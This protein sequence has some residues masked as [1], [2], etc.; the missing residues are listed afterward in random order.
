MIQEEFETLLN[1]VTEKLSDEARKETPF[2]TSKDFENRVRE[3]LVEFGKDKNIDIDFAPHSYV[4]PDIAVGEF[5]IEVKFTAND[6]WRSVANSVFESTRNLEVTQV[7]IIFGKMGGIPAVRWGKYENC[8]MHVR[9]SHV[10][11]FEVEM[12]PEELL[13]E[14]IGITYKD[15]CDLPTEGK[16]HYIRQYARGRL[17]PGERLWW[18]EEKPE[19]EHSLP[20]QV[21]LFMHLS[22]EEKRKVRAEATLLCPQIVKSSRARNKYNDAALY[23]LTYHGVMCPQAR[24]LFSAGSVA[25]RANQT[26]GG[27]YIE[28]ALK[29]IESEMREA[30]ARL[31]DALFVEYWGE[32]VEPESRISKWLARADSLAKDWK[33]SDVLFKE[34]EDE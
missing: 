11:R 29:D 9:T 32:S 1:D 19:Q 34:A 10:P 13:F 25:L 16:M 23:L 31:E 8:V 7:Y 24:D 20:I 28:R 12:Y 6:T 3:V 22:N 2:K 33:P 17:K 21:R 4:F 15:F 5:G 26:R 14:K 18:L 27:R 30:A